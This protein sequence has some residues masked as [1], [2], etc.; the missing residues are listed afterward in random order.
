MWSSMQDVPA[1]VRLRRGAPLSLDGAQFWQAHF[2]LLLGTGSPETAASDAAW[3]AFEQQYRLS[4]GSWVNAS[5]APLLEVNMGRVGYV[6]AILD[7]GYPRLEMLC[8]SATLDAYGTYV[9]PEIIPLFRAQAAIG[10]RAQTFT[11]AASLGCTMLRL[12]HDRTHPFPIGWATAT[13]PADQWDLYSWSEIREKV[14]VSRPEHALVYRHRLR[15]D[16]P[17]FQALVS[18]VTA[19][20][21]LAASL[22]MLHV[23]RRRI[24]SD[25]AQ[26]DVCAL[27]GPNARAD[28]VALIFEMMGANPDA[29]FGL[30]GIALQ[31]LFDGVDPLQARRSRFRISLRR[32]DPSQ[33]PTEGTPMPSTDRSVPLQPYAESGDLTG[34]ELFS[35][36]LKRRMPMRTFDSL[37]ETLAE[38]LQS[39]AWRHRE[40]GEAGLE[41]EMAAILEAFGEAVAQEVLDGSELRSDAAWSAFFGRAETPS[42]GG[43]TMSRV[44]EFLA[45]LSDEERAELRANMGEPAPPPA[46][47][48]PSSEEPNPATS[49]TTPNPEPAPP[50]EP[51]APAAAE[52]APAPAPA[53]GDTGSEEALQAV[54]DLVR[55]DLQA[56]RA[57]IA[58]VVGPLA[59]DL[60]EV[61]AHLGLDPAGSDAPAAPA[62][63]PSGVVTSETR[64]LP[65]PPAIEPQVPPSLE[66]IE[67]KEGNRAAREAGRARAR[68][69]VMNRLG[70]P[71]QPQT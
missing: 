49:P 28:H 11:E 30:L 67:A 59:A 63:A 53:P 45:G 22:G 52:P 25:L 20:R 17:Y 42:T 46:T 32:G 7:Q 64:T 58:E 61:R 47:Q 71:P 60:Q 68:E 26:R 2:N 23:Y 39:A 15:E 38:A 19:G 48:P 31:S 56:L 40:T 10:E 35:D 27:V 5:E 34:A 69:V 36:L 57:E 51:P 1:N 50:A 41:A 29:N 55:R 3:S 33:P 4:N 54:T 6:Q 66:E 8:G 13:I 12:T 16:H 62:P 24:R 70:L 65:T 14:Q 21:P 43:A 44:T 37:I 18:D 9:S